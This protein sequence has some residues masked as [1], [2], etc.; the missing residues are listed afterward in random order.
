M[1]ADLNMSVNNLQTIGAPCDEIANYGKRPL[2]EESE[3][4]L[5]L[6]EALQKRHFISQFKKEEKGIRIITKKNNPSE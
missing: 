3:A 5:A 1:S 6:A 4:N 2:I